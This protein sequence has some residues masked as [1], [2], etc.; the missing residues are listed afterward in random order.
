MSTTGGKAKY[1]NTKLKK[2]W[3]NY[4]KDYFMKEGTSPTE[5]SNIEMLET[6]EHYYYKIPVLKTDNSIDYIKYICTNN[7]KSSTTSTIIIDFF[8]F[9]GLKNCEESCTAFSKNYYDPSNHECLE[10]CIGREGLEYANYINFGATGTE[11]APSPTPCKSECDS[12]NEHYNFGTKICLNGANCDNGKFIKHGVNN[13]CYDSCSEI[14]SEEILYEIVNSVISVCYAKTEI[15]DF[16]IDCPYYFKKDEKTVKCVNALSYCVSAGFNYLYKTECI[17]NCGDYYKFHDTTNNIIKCYENYEKAYDDNSDIKYY[18]TTLKELWT[19]TTLPTN[20]F[21]LF[22]NNGA[23]YEVVQVC[24]FYYYENANGNNYCTDDCQSVHLHFAKDNKKCESSCNS[25]NKKYYNPKNQECLDTCSSLND[26]KYSNPIITDDSATPPT[27]IPQQCIEICP[28]YYI[29]KIDINNKIIY[30]CVNNCPP[31]NTS[32]YKLIDIKTKEC[33]QSC[34]T[35]QMQD[36]ATN[37]KYCFPKCDVANDFVYIDTDTYS[38][39][40]ACPSYL[41]KLE[42][43]GIFDGKEVF[44]CK[45]SCKEEEYRLEDKCLTECP[46]GFN[47]I[48]FNKICKEESCLLDPNGQYY[49]PINEYDTP[50]PDHLIYKCVQ[51]CNQAS[52]EI[53]DGTTKNYFYYDKSTELE[54][55]K[56]LEQC[57]P[58]RPYYLD[59][60][61]Y[62]CLS[63]CPEKFPFYTN[64]ST[65]SNHILCSNVNHCISENK[66]FENGNCVPSCTAKYISSDKRCLDKCPENE[67]KK[68]SSTFDSDGTYNCLRTCGDKYIYKENVEDEPECVDY[69]PNGYY[70]GK[71]NVCKTSCDEEDGLF[72]YEIDFTGADPALPST[73]YKLFKCIDGCKGRYLYREVDNGNQ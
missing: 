21:I 38:C 43:L 70:V 34:G 45:S 73:D 31:E 33:L 2:C 6:C 47:Y 69:C 61:E 58:E 40:K 25:F 66:F 9:P 28:N 12:S 42:L 64:P 63:K 23:N 3:L 14:P 52:T 60:N 68:K 10:T 51:S 46:S 41:K 7:C 32:P 13:V 5:T 37:P 71:D 24:P 17:K 1:F 48:G 20:M 57:P 30:E 8:Y 18:D 35:E 54:P 50:S 65:T 62:E 55:Y 53:S 15:S 27:P 22:D 16:A 11:P 49:F 4:P 36:D 39:V 26:L 56:C 72:Y 59:S 29:Q 67:I 19:D 44:L